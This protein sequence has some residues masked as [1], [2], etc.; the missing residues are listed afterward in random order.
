MGRSSGGV[1]ELSQ[2]LQQDNK[3]M[4]AN[5]KR[6]DR[7][8]RREGLQLWATGRRFREHDNPD[9]IRSVAG[10]CWYRPDKAGDK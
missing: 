10:V 5:G 8:K 3:T 6:V 7:P 4:G 1:A 9:S 2:A